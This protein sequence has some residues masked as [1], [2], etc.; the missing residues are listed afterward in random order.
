MNDNRKNIKLKENTECFGYGLSQPD[1]DNQKYN[2]A[3][4]KN[5]MIRKKVRVKK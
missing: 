4:Y 1:S 5:S 2:N 3:G